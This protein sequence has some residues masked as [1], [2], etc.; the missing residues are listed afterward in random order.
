MPFYPSVYIKVS[1]YPLHVHSVFLST[2]CSQRLSIH[3]MFTVS[4]YPLHN[5]SVFLS[6]ARSQCLSIHCIITASFYP[7]HVHSV[8]L[9]TARSQCLSIHC[10]FTVSFYPKLRSLGNSS[11]ALPDWKKNV[12]SRPEIYIPYTHTP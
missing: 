7:L 9:S 1:F 10:T 3:C 11:V 12:V 8:F 6:T 2:A 4:F 5:H